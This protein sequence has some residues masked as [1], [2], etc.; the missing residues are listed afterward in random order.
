MQSWVAQ[1]YPN[2]VVRIISY[3]TVWYPYSTKNEICIP[4][5]M[6][7]PREMLMPREMLLPPVPQSVH[8]CTRSPLFSFTCRLRRFRAKRSFSLG[9]NSMDRFRNSIDLV[10][11]EAHLLQQYDFSFLI[12]QHPGC[13]GIH[14]EKNPSSKRAD[15]IKTPRPGHQQVADHTDP[16]Q[17]C[18]RSA[19]Y[20]PF[21]K[22]GLFR[23]YNI[24][25]PG[26]SNH[27]R[28][29]ARRVAEH[30]AFHNLFL[31]KTNERGGR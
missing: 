29:G 16:C 6:L 23:Y 22:L 31:G 14:H 10:K 28:G 13:C 4:Q 12:P 3:G 21:W 25:D 2:T 27:D 18:N 30:V 9:F 19:K 24:R 26:R 15:K 17:C 1:C 20:E 7:L 5:E 8:K 11:R